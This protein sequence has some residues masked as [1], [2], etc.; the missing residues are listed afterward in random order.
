LQRMVQLAS[1]P[2][3]SLMAPS[4]RC[5]GNIVTGDDKQTQT[6]ID[7]GILQTVLPLALTSNKGGLTREACWLISNICAGIP[8]QIQ[9]VLDSSLLPEVIHLLETGDFRTQT[10]AAWVIYN[11]SSGGTT[12]QACTLFRYGALTNICR[13][14]NNNRDPRVLLLVMDIIGLMLSIADKMGQLEQA[15]VIVEECGGLDNVEQLQNHENEEVYQKAL[16][17][18]EKYFTEMEEVGDVGANGD[19]PMQFQDPGADLK[20]DF[21]F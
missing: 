15:T 13:L 12:E 6:V 7:C 9:A 8:P 21:Q 5:L 3:M 17:L 18:V 11:I 16:K 1:G 4:L 10:E 19:G 20:E 2:D 14:L